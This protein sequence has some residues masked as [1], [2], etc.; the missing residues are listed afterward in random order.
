MRRGSIIGYD[1]NKDSCQISYYNEDHHEPETL[2]V[3]ADNY[4]ILW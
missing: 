4:Q 2:Q 1:L 3:A